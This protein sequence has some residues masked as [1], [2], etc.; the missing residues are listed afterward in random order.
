ETPV[1]AIISCSVGRREP[2]KSLPLTMSAV[3]RAT[4]SPG[5]PREA[6]SGLSSARFFCGRLFNVLTPGPCLKSSYDR[7]STTRGQWD[8]CAVPRDEREPQGEHRKAKFTM[9]VWA[10]RLLVRR[11]CHTT[12]HV[13][14]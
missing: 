5:S 10:A 9:D 6:S 12:P 1:A 14:T 3:R 13:K 4:S 2:G 11:Q 8:Q 7:T